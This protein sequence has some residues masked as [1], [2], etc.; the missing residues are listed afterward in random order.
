MMILLRPIF[1]ERVLL[2][3]WGEMASG[4]EAS[5]G[6]FLIHGR[7]SSDERP[8][9]L[10]VRSAQVRRRGRLPEDRRRSRS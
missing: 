6:R 4:S 7:A 8:P 1:M 2:F 10:L 3:P 5:A 9:Y